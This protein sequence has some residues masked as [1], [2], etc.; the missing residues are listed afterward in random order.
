MFAAFVLSPILAPFVWNRV[1]AGHNSIAAHETTLRD[2]DSLYIF[3]S[4]R[5]IPH[6]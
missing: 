1:L 6:W 3:L 2:I 5:F 4:F